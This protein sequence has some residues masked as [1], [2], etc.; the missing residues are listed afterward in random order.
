M[1]LLFVSARSTL[2]FN[3]SHHLFNAIFIVALFCLRS[4]KGHLPSFSFRFTVL[5]SSNTSTVVVGNGSVC[6]MCLILAQKMLLAFNLD[7]AYACMCCVAVHKLSFI[8]VLY[9]FFTRC[10]RNSMLCVCV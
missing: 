6:W 9:I 1:L 5:N 2:S 4:A 7:Y 3:H 8:F 10:F